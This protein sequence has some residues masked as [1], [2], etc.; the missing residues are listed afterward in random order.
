[1]TTTSANRRGT[2]MATVIAVVAASAGA[3]VASPQVAKAALVVVADYR[4]DENTIGPDRLMVD[5]GPL[6]LDG[7]IGDSIQVGSIGAGV[8]GYQWA[9]TPPDTGPE[10]PERLAVIDNDE[11]LNPGTAE[12]AIEFRYRTT[13]SFGNIAQKGQSNTDGGYWKIEQPDGKVTCLFRHNQSNDVAVTSP[14]RT[15]DGAW[16][17]IRCERRGTFVRMLIDGTEVV[18]NN[19]TVGSIANS[20]PL[21]IGGKVNCNQVFVGCDYFTGAIDYLKVEKDIPEIPNE[22]PVMQLAAPQCTNLTCTFDSSGSNDPDGTIVDRAW[23]F[24]D[25]A[26]V[27]HQDEIAI[28]SFPSAGTYTVSIVGTDELGASSV[29]ATR[30]VTVTGPPNQPPQM[31][32]AISCVG[33]TCT[34]DTASATDPDGSIVSR[35][36]QFGDGATQAGGAATVQHTFAADGAYTVRVVGTDD[37]GA[38]DVITRTVAVPWPSKMIPVSPSRLFDTRPGEPAPGPEGVVVGGTSID[39]QVTGVGPVPPTGV[40]AVAINLTAIGVQAPSFVA[41]RPA[42]TPE[43]TTSSINLVTPG[44]VRANM[45][46]VPVGAGGKISLTSLRD[47]HLLGDIAGYFV[48][49]DRTSDDGRIVTQAPQRLFDTRPGAAP[50]PKGLVPSASAITV[51]VLGRAGVPATGVTAVVLNV[52]V[53]ET[54][55]PGFVTAFPSGTTRP[56]ASSINVNRQ[57]ETVAN[58]VI[59]PLGV[60]GAISLFTLSGAHLVADVFG[61]VTDDAAGTTSTGLFVPLEPSRVFDTREGEPGGGPKGL[62]AAGTTIRPQ[63]AGVAGIPNAAGG[64][65]LN[66]T[67]IGSAP[68][69]ATIWPA[70]RDRPD[71]SNVNVVGA[72]DVRPNGAIVQLGEGGDVDV[73]ALAPA[74]LLADAFGYLLA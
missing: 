16:H 48:P 28:H 38:V 1:M 71:T 61:Y 54:E 36:W 3:L 45:V 42:G 69:F 9:F 49:V 8:S 27:E 32:L 66:V 65:V 46:I 64:V 73:F 43:S 74:H 37:R 33:R 22:H 29:P 68:S 40:T 51:P 24:G 35:S 2:R 50:G 31:Q 15:N 19:K 26:E 39:V 56:T 53:T 70:G 6:G 47:A 41:A 10:D 14:V 62:V 57:G 55:G 60:D 20:F 44:E 63:V 34:F 30:Q 21:T 72:G 4:M 67:M 52:T 7:R 5:S 13:R 25:G 58:Q 59:V 12:F 18:R 11:N 23:D 17:T